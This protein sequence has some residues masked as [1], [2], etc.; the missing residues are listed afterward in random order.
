MPRTI[1][2]T[3]P[4]L[5]LEELITAIRAFQVASIAEK[6]ALIRRLVNIHPV[7]SLECVAGWRYR[8]ARRLT[9]GEIPETVDELIWRK[10]IPAA[11]GRANPAGFQVLYLADRPDTAFREVR[12]DNELVVL[13]E[14][15]ILPGRSIRVVPIGELAQIQ[16]TGHGFLSGHMSS[17]ISDLLN[18]CDLNQAKSL[19][20]A[21]AFLLECLT[22]ADDN[23][24]VSSAVAM[25]IFDRLPAVSA[26]SYP[27]RRQI[28]AINFAV[29]VEQFWENWGIGSVRRG[30]AIH[31][32]QGY[33]RFLEVRHVNGVTVDGALRWRDEPDERENAVLQ[34]GPLWRPRGFG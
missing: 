30:R 12:V 14:C 7:V 15:E 23:Y 4:P 9:E 19:L 13:T 17:T 32:A 2:E 28:G 29:R 10:G 24:E 25:S 8:R 6:Q 26:V 31:L 33:Y 3:Y 1:T 27:S 18:A 34:L 21:D 22:T 5:P 16:R 20:I 11:L